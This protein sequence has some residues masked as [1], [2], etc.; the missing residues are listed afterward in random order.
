M[1][2]FQSDPCGW[3][4]RAAQASSRHLGGWPRQADS[5]LP[6]RRKSR[7][8]YVS[9]SPT[10]RTAPKA[11][12]LFASSC[13]Q[14]PEWTGTM[15]LLMD[16][17]RFVV[18]HDEVIH[19]ADDPAQIDLLVGRVRHRLCP[20]KIIHRILI[21]DRRYSS[22]PKTPGECWKG[23]GC[24]VLR[25]VTDFILNISGQ[26]KIILPVLPFIARCRAEAGP[27]EDSQPLKIRAMRSSTMMF[28]ATTRKLVERSV[29]A[30][31]LVEIAPGHQQAT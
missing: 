13:G 28:G 29:S 11:R 25:D 24:P 6:S 20:K 31:K 21:V 22:F 1:I 30:H 9:V 15:H 26:L 5:R 3:L 16:V 10:D 8:C 7:R 27:R 14:Y 2:V 17:V 4:G 19:F 23:T 18:Q 12:D